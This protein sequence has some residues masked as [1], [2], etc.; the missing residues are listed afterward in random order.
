MSMLASKYGQ[1][2]V[3]PGI[4]LCGETILHRR[5]IANCYMHVDMLI[6]TVSQ[7]TMTLEIGI[8][9]VDK[10]TNMS[11]ISTGS[12]QT[13]HKVTEVLYTPTC[14]TSL[15]P[16]DKASYVSHTVY[17]LSSSP[18][19]LQHVGSWAA[20]YNENLPQPSTL[21]TVAPSSS[22]RPTLMDLDLIELVNWQGVGLQL[23]IKD[24]ELQKIELDYHQHDERNREVFRVWLRTQTTANYD[25]LIK[26]LEV[27]GEKTVAQQLRGRMYI[28]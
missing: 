26:A 24:Y 13:C 22:P 19:C 9:G 6:S 11:I 23:G 15:P 25:D 18:L 7:K 28:T 17:N 14:T 27:V 2:L 1:T 3:G 10:T 20:E 4:V 5:I 16:L 12:S 21:V 8:S